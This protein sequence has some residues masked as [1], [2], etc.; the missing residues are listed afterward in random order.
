MELSGN[1]KFFY[2]WMPFLTPTSG[3]NGPHYYFSDFMSNKSVHYCHHY[4]EVINKYC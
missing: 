2:G 3:I 4:Y 1:E